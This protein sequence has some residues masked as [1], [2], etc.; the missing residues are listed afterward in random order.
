MS[1]R[2]DETIE[3]KNYKLQAIE[4]VR[5]AAERARKRHAVRQSGFAFP[6]VSQDLSA[7]VALEDWQGS[8]KRR[9]A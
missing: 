6:W 3:Q 8:I 7:P 9:A 4:F 2:A 1:Y 5:L